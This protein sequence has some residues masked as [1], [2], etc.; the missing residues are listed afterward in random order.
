[1]AGCTSIQ[2]ELSMK[3]TIAIDTTTLQFDQDMVNY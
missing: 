3:L 2:L 1:N